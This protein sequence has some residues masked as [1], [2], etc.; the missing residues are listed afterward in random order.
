LPRPR[1]FFNKTLLGF[2]IEADVAEKFKAK[3]R[4]LGVDYSQVLREFVHS[5]I[6]AEP[7]EERRIITFNIDLKVEVV[8]KK[9][10]QKAK[11]ALELARELELKEFKEKLAIWKQIA[12][13]TRNSYE[14]YDIKRSITK[15]L[16]RIREADNDTIDEVKSLLE[17]IDKKLE[18]LR[19]L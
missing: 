8:E 2:A 19:R 4:E 10:E 11:N 15:S 18:Q 7:K 14:L 9:V 6:L 17:L 13:R 3:C 5:F 1:L 16:R 12:T